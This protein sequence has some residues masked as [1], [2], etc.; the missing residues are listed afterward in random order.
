MRITFFYLLMIFFT[1]C[2]QHAA[3]ENSTVEVLP[4][5]KVAEG[6]NITWH[7]TGT[8]PFWNMYIHN[9]T[10]IYTRLNEKIDTIFFKLD[11]YAAIVDGMMYWVSDS[12]KQEAQIN[13]FKQKDPCSDGMSDRVYSYHAKLLYKKEALK[14]CAEK[15]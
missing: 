6:K 13:I 7:I 15:K 14:G 11:D 3:K 4:T 1:G 9:D 5:E 8:E 10:F 2:K 12:I